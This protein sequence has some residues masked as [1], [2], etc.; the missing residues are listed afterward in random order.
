M[1]G[2]HPYN[3]VG[4]VFTEEEL[5]KICEICYEYDVLVFSDEIHADFVFEKDLQDLILLAQG[6]SYRGKNNEKI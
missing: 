3:P 4:R 2:T 5:T 6:V 1:R